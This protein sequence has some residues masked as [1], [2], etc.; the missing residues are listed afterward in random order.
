MNARHGLAFD[1]KDVGMRRLG[2]LH[3]V[4][5]F[6]RSR[7]RH[8]RSPDAAAAVAALQVAAVALHD[9]PG[10]VRLGFRS[11]PEAAW[12]WLE[13]DVDG[14]EWFAGSLATSA[15]AARQNLRMASPR[16]SRVPEVVGLD[17]EAAIEHLAQ[18]GFRARLADESTSFDRRVVRQDPPAN[19]PVPSERI[20]V[21]LYV[22]K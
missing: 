12:Q 22:A 3:G 4:C 11:S 14:A 18:A 6:L 19:A 13:L 2:L 10:I 17:G 5:E 21:S 8:A 16:T 20:V 7:R 9:K 1:R 15:E